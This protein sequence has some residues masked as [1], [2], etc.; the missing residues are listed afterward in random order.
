MTLSLLDVVRQYSEL[1]SDHEG[2]GR[3]E[4]P[5]L[6]TLRIT[7]RTALSYAVQKP[8][9]C[10]VLQGTKHVMMGNQYFD[11]QAGDSLLIMADVP[12]ASQITKADARDPYLS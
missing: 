10:L 11:F 8:L 12:T 4:I 6:S 1:H 7:S 3:T 9:A 5:G 2:V